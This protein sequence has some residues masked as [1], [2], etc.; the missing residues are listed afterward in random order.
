MS[1]CTVPMNDKCK[2][3]YDLATSATAKTNVIDPIFGERD[4]QAICAILKEA[5]RITCCMNSAQ[6]TSVPIAIELSQILDKFGF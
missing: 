1:N 4:R 5:H 3:P 6:I 2:I